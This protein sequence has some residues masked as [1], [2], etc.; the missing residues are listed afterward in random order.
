MEK[1]LDMFGEINEMN[2]T[3]DRVLPEGVKLDAKQS[4]CPYCSKPVIFVMDKSLGVKRCP[5]CGISDKDFNVR[6][7]NNKWV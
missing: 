2:E 7:I 1:Q 4:W 3:P 5:Y 6:M